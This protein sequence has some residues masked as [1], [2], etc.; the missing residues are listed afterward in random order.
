MAKKERGAL[1]TFWLILMLIL[2][3]VTALLY[4]LGGKFVAAL[5]PLIPVWAIYALGILSL[6]HV[7]FTIFLF[8]W[9]KWAF[10]AIC[11]SICVVLVINLMIG[12]GMMS[13]L[14]L[15]SPVILYLIMKPKWGL[16]G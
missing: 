9:K 10:F 11:A 12:I 16:F 2:N 7:I 15:L 8:M 13:F 3:G 1:L 5:S 4:L 14:G 6:L